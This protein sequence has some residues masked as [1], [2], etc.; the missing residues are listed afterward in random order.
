MVDGSWR[1]PCYQ[2]HHGARQQIAHRKKHRYQRSSDSWLRK[3]VH[4]WN[5]SLTY[6]APLL[7]GH[8]RAENTPVNGD[9]ASVENFRMNLSSTSSLLALSCIKIY[10]VKPK[11]LSCQKEMRG[12]VSPSGLFSTLLPIYFNICACPNHKDERGLHHINH[13]CPS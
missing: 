12:S 7:A 3:Q 8:N 4:T 6:T 5:S 9:V 1:V 10:S 2:L 11:Q 13:S